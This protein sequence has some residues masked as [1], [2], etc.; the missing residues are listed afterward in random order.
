MV[1]MDEVLDLVL[2]V[3]NWFPLME[4]PKLGKCFK[5]KLNTK[6]KILAVTSS[7]AHLV[8]ASPRNGSSGQTASQRTERE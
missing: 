5:D 8:T 2:Y 1:M 4:G 7:D 3:K 6:L